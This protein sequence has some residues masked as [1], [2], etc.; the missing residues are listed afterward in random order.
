M[1]NMKRIISAVLCLCIIFAS[2]LVLTSCKEKEQTPAPIDEA[3]SVFV[4]A[5]DIEEGT[6]ITEDMLKTVTTD[7]SN[8]PFN[9]IRDIAK[10][11][12]MITTQ[13]IYAGEFFFAAKLTEKIV[14]VEDEFS[15]NL[16]VTEHIKT[17]GDVATKIQELINANPGRTLEFPD[18]EYIV[19]KPIKVPAD[20]AKGVSLRLSSY[21]VIKAA[22]NFSGDAVIC[23]ADGQRNSE[24]ESNSFYLSG[25]IIDGNGKADVAV[26]VGDARDILISN[27]TV[28]NAE[29]GIKVVKGAADLENIHITAT[30]SANSVGL[31]IEGSEGSAANIQISNVETGVKVTG[32][33]NIFK[34]V[35]ARYS[36]SSVDSCGFIDEGT[37]SNYDMCQSYQFATGFKMAEKS[38]SVYYACYVTWTDEA[39]GRNWAF[40]SAG[41][42]NALIRNCLVDFA[43]SG[44]DASFIK[45]GTSG[46]EGQI[47]YPMIG[48]KNNIVNNEYNQYMEGTS[49][50]T[51]D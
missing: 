25:G 22:S 35:F 28:R 24:S 8:I 42:F 23:L 4:A 47:L 49:I 40:Q 21:A 41:K 46:G 45:A 20:C 12:D 13:K 15:A 39:L 6:K 9:A 17:G 37:G 19:S 30:G 18:G 3:I 44:H 10:I 32:S 43:F 29:T 31:L 51:K 2:A 33:N 36:G 26:S 34:S 38:N 1:K 48:G 27:V 5:S 11:K 7:L 50:I 14:E 16:V